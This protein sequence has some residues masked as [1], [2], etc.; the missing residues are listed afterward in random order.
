RGADRGRALVRRDRAHQLRLHRR[1]LAGDHRARVRDLRRRRDLLRLHPGVGRRSQPP[2]RG[3]PLRITMLLL[4]YLRMAFESLRTNKLR[5]AL[6]LLGIVIGVFSVIA[7]VTAVQV[8]DVYFNDAFR[9][10]GANTFYVS[11]YGGGIQ[12]GPRDPSLRN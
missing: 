10:M 2:D 11:K 12:I 7:A 6:A 9:G 8:I 1:P 5:S 4:E 3:A